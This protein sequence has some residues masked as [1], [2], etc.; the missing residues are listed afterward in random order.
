MPTMERPGDLPEDFH[1]ED[2]Y[3]CYRPLA[4]VTFS[5]VV[6]LCSAALTYS[7]IHNLERL[8]VDTTGLT[9][10]QQPTTIERFT[11]G[12]RCAVAAG[13]ALTVAFLAKPEMIDPDFFGARV[14]RNRGL[15]ISIFASEAAAVQWLL[16][17]ISQ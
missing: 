7:R 9:G 6:E 4:D 8:L 15:R 11:L 14:A 17:P 16:D 1:T 12:E 13:G 10:F 5:E 2:G 3:T